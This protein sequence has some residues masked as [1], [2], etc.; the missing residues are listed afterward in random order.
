MDGAK[1]ILWIKQFSIDIG[2]PQKSVI[3]N[4]DNQSAIKLIKNPFSH[5]RSKHIDVR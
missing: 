3:L 1:E 4:I 5:K 2:E